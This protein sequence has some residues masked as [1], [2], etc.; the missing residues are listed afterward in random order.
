MRNRDVGNAQPAPMRLKPPPGLVHLA[1]TALARSLRY[2][3][4]GGH[5][6]A[7]AIALSPTRSVVFC[8]WHQSLLG[9]LG[10]HHGQRVA[11]LT[12]LSGDGTIMA[13]YIGRIGLRP[14]RGSS[15]RG[16]LKAARELM[17]AVSEG[18]HAAITVDGPR[19]PFKEV[20]PGPFEISRR[21]GAPIVP[22][23]V[24][25]S[26]EISFKRAW[27]RFRLPLP[28]ARMVLI[29]GPPMVLP[30]EYPSPDEIFAR[31]V[32][33]ARRLHDLEACAG[34]LV[35]RTGQGPVPACLAWMQAGATATT[36]A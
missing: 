36:E 11:A 16:G 27:D 31:R 7:R 32:D 19:G 12:S 3:S 18:W 24:R 28:G 6:L 23:A 15:S 22:V 25:A 9:V 34:A 35:G 10:R 14:I 20:K 2:R 17:K 29:Y 13:E 30:P 5:H 33:L 26:R 8:L 1:G 4:L 21:T